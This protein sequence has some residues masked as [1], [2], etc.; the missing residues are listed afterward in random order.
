MAEKNRNR[1]G[2]CA[3]VG[4]PNVG[5]STLLNRLIGQKL[6]ITSRKPQTTR[7]SILG[8]KTTEQGQVIYVDTPGIHQRGDQAMNK[9][10]NRTAKTALAD[11]DLLVFVV[12]ANRWT[13]EDAAVLQTIKNI[14]TPTILVVNKVD[15]VKEKQS[16]LPFLSE[17]AAKHPFEEVIPLS[18]MSGDNADMLGKQVLARLPESENFFPEDQLTDRPERFFAAEL[19]REQLTRR[20][21]KEIPYALTVEIE[22]FEQEG[23]LYRI[24]ALVWVERPGQK[25]IIIGSKGAALKEVAKQA[26]LE[27]EKFF[28][29]KVFL[30]IWVKV[31]K[32][33]SSDESALIR[34]GYGD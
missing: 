11:V 34:L 3:I 15:T 24:N 18:T 26:R 25:N 27:M 19:I 14:G 4:R 12:E 10:L 30:T 31:K 9:Y 2:Y 29:T 33:W 7:H 6:A 8:V 1:C 21:A 23:N 28:G 17:I 22:K 20:Y 13:D 16:L 32:S 5:K